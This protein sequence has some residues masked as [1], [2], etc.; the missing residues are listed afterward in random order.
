MRIPRCPSF[1]SKNTRVQIKAQG[2]RVYSL[3]RNTVT[4]KIQRREMEWI[5]PGVSAR[6]C[7]SQRGYF[8]AGN[9]LTNNRSDWR[10]MM[11]GGAVVLQMTAPGKKKRR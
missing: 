11:S 9:V 2:G 3:S 7:V 6:W 8:D 4:L 5:V 10:G 1:V